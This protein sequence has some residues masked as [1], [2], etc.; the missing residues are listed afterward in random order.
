ML[1][2]Q[3]KNIF[4]EIKDTMENQYNIKIDA[5]TI[6]ETVKSGIHCVGD[7]IKNSYRMFE[8][9]YQ[10]ETKSRIQQNNEF[11]LGQVAR[12]ICMELS[13]FWPEQYYL[14]KQFSVSPT[15]VSC[16]TVKCI[17]NN[18]ITIALPK[19]SWNTAYSA[20]ALQMLVRRLNGTLPAFIQAY[21]ALYGQQY[22]L[23]YS[24]HMINLQFLSA[25]DTGAEIELSIKY[26]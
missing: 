14:L 6:K 8:E 26:I 16:L 23:Q 17:T 10:E 24:P 2:N 1:D 12:Q 21:S 18:M 5:E 25:T 22:F 13:Y 19:Y 7:F 11:Y 20:G 3:K 15:G 4:N 9:R